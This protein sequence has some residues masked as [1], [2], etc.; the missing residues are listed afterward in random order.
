MT[1]GV[2][3]LLARWRFDI[4]LRPFLHRCAVGPT[5]A[6][7]HISS[8]G[9]KNI[10]KINKNDRIHVGASCIPQPRPPTAFFLIFFFTISPGRQ[11]RPC[12][13]PFLSTPRLLHNS[14]TPRLLSLRPWRPRPRLGRLRRRQK[15]SAPGLNL[16]LRCR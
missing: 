8:F 2:Y 3:T 14:G 13:H 1:Y 5:L 15:P 9:T 6:A 10:I 7:Y 16:G 12:R 11:N 4:I